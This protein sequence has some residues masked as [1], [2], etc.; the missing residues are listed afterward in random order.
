M[1]RQRPRKPRTPEVWKA[2]CRRAWIRM[3]CV[4][5]PEGGCR[6]MRHG[7]GVH[8]LA[9]TVVM[10]TGCTAAGGGGSGTR[11][12]DP[13]RAAPPAPG[14]AAPGGLPRA[15]ARRPGRGVQGWLIGM[16]VPP[17]LVQGALVRTGSAAL[18]VRALSN[19]DRYALT[20]LY[21]R[22]VLT[23]PNPELG[24]LGGEAPGG[25]ALALAAT[26]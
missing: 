21:D 1:I 25:E 2:P 3:L 22:A 4:G 13:V 14:A 18:L 24:T 5:N 15:G 6:V 20:R 26:L 9:G 23:G 17:R 16:V 12:G 11:A 8:A 7:R 10:V 19:V